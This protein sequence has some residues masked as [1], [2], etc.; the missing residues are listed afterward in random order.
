MDVLR[1]ENLG[2]EFEASSLDE[3]ASLVLEH[4]V[5]IGDGDELIVAEALGVGDVGEVRVAL[6]AVPADDERVVDL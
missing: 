1:A 6:L 2:P 5:V 3:V 4:R